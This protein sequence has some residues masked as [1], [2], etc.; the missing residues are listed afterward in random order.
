[1]KQAAI[2]LDRYQIEPAEAFTFRIETALAYAS[3]FS[4][5][6]IDMDK[7]RNAK[8]RAYLSTIS[9]WFLIHVDLARLADVTRDNE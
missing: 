9:N 1:V 4:E 6:T 2:R 5:L 7:W 3:I 8:L